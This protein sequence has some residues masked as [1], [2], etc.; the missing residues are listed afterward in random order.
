MLD[1]LLQQARRLRIEDVG[2]ASHFVHRPRRAVV[3]NV[4]IRRFLAE[5]ARAPD[6]VVEHEAAADRLAAGAGRADVVDFLDLERATR[7][8]PRS[9]GIGTRGISP[10][11]SGAVPLTTHVGGADDEIGRADR[12]F[13]LSRSTTRG[14]GMSASSP[15]GAPLSAHFAIERDLVG[16]QRR[17]VLEVLDA[18]VLLDIPRRH[19][20]GARA[21]AGALLDRAR[22]RP[23]FFVGA[24]R[25][26]RHAVG[27]MAVLAAALQDRRD[28]LGER[29][30]GGDRRREAAAAAPRPARSRRV[31]GPGSLRQATRND[32][33]IGR[34]LRSGKYARLKGR[35]GC[36]RATVHLVS[37]FLNARTR[38]DHQAALLRWRRR[39]AD[40]AGVACGAARAVDPVGFA[41]P[42]WPPS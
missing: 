26:R 32:A 14:G 40:R 28:V 1:P 29:D 5:H 27:P 15:R 24:Q 41:G 22:P 18:D 12:P 25:H 8:D 37:G 7:S 30:F 10:H 2:F 11:Q 4:G 31:A 3:G 35:A 13:R 21:D 42:W 17:I 36:A 9:S 19:H 39:S 16:A 34:R 38:V 20:A 23:H 6:H 33:V